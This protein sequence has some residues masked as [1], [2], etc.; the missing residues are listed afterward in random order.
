MADFDERESEATAER[1]RQHFVDHPHA[2]SARY[3]RTT[4]MMILE[5]YN[6]CKFAFPPRQVQGLADATDEQLAK[7]EMSGWGF[8]LHWDELD[9]DITVPGLLSGTFG[10]RRFMD[11]HRERL[12]AILSELEH[13]DLRPA[14]E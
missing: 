10:T 11:Q 12:R 1:G 3:D 14:A 13:A 7:V 9:V 6:G 8:G 4:E 5:L 2:R